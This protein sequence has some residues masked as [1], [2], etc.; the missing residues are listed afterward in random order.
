MSNHYMC[1]KCLF[2]TSK[3]YNIIKHFN[4][5]RKCVRSTSCSYN[6]EEIKIL[7]EKQLEEKFKHKINNEVMNDLIQK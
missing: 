1:Y 7:N 4:R 5:K 3:R 2:K 6:D